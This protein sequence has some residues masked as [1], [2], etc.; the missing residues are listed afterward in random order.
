MRA[1]HFSRAALVDF[2]HAF[3]DLGQVALLRHMRSTR[4]RSTSGFFF[5]GQLKGDSNWQ[6]LSLRLSSS[7]NDI[8]PLVTIF[9]GFAQGAATLVRSRTACPKPLIKHP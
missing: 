1:Q 9:D 6:I 8:G 5:G 7:L 3:N 4:L 2:E